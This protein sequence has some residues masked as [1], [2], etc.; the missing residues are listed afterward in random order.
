MRCARHDLAEAPDGKCILCRRAAAHRA[1]L[2]PWVVLGGIAVV[3]GVCAAYRASTSRP[4]PATGDTG[5]E[6][7]PRPER[8]AVNIV[9]YTTRWCSVCRRAKKWMS[10]QGIAYEERDVE[11][12]PENARRMRSINPRGSVPTFDLDGQVLVG[13]SQPDL[14]SAMR[15]AADR[16]S[17]RL[18]R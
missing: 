5:F 1:P 12:S 14:E 17:A 7:A 3:L 11:T 2:E 4:V 18:P 13:F 9:V 10:E 16:S 8:G 15:H 6:P